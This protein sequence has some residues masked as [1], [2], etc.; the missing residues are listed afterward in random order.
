MGFQTHH[1]FT[2]LM[3]SPPLLRESQKL[4]LGDVSLEIALIVDR[5]INEVGSNLY[6]VSI[7]LIL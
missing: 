4:P 3:I 2:Y 6:R 5:G 7:H 1:P